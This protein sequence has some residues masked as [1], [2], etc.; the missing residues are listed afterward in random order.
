MS[1]VKFLSYQ[2]SNE[3]VGYGGQ[4]TFNAEQIRIMANGDSCNESFWKLSNHI[5]THIDTPFHFSVDGKKI[6]DYPASHWVYEK[7]QVVELSLSFGELIS[8]KIVS[9]IIEED[10]ELLLLKTGFGAYKGK[11]EYWEKNPGLSKDLAAW[12]RDNRPK[13][14]TIGIDL[15]S[16]T[17]Y[18]HRPEGKIA[19]DAF[20]SPSHPGEPFTVIEDM[21]LSDIDKSTK[22]EKVVVSP[23]VVKNADGSPVTVFAFTS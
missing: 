11:R 20:L 4:T 6:S 8:P 17:S 10:T 12:I 7:I 19:H 16:I 23:L 22:I 13:V 2:L 15:I 18:M 1:E 5:G 14:R 9:D 21:Q 3:T